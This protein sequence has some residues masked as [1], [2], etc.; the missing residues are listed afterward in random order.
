MFGISEN[1]L[2]CQEIGKHHPKEKL[3]EK[4]KELIEMMKLTGKDPKTAI[5]YFINLLKNVKE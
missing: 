3:I 4:D 5:M 1:F 2:V